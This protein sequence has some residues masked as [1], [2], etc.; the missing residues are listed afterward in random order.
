[1]T[2]DQAVLSP[3]YGGVPSRNRTCVCLATRFRKPM[4]HPLGYGDI[5]LRHEPDEHT[6]DNSLRNNRINASP[7]TAG[8][9]TSTV[10]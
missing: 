10:S 1:M 5:Q 6:L 9:R 4:P 8:S 2:A 3:T 7:A